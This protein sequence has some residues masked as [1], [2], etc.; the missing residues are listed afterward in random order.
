MQSLLKNIHIFSNLSN[1]DLEYLVNHAEELNLSA[2]MVL[3][4]EGTPSDRAY[5]I[6]KGQLELVKSFPNREVILGIHKS[7]EML[8]EK[9]LLDD[10]SH[11]VTIRARSDCE[12]VVITKELFNNLIN[13][14]PSAARAILH[15]INERWQAAESSLRKNEKVIMLGSL[16]A[17]LAHE[18]NNPA[19]SV[20][21]GVK[22][23]LELVI[24]FEKSLNDLNSVSLTENQKEIVKRLNDRIQSHIIHPLKLDTIK[25]NDRIDTFEIWLTNQ[26]IK[27]A[28]ELAP[29]LVN[30]SFDVNEVGQIS[31]QF[32][33][34]QRPSLFRWL[35]HKYSI[36]TLLAEINYGAEQ[37]LEIGKSLKS[38]SYRDQGSLQKVQNVDVHQGLEDSLIILRGLLKKGI[39]II[40]REFEPNLPQI[41]ALSSAKLSQVWINLLHNAID[42]L[43]GQEYK[44]IIIRTRSESNW[45][46]VDFEDN[47]SGIPQNI[48]EKIFNPFFTTKPEGKGTG[49]GLDISHRI[50]VYEHYGEISVSSQPGLTKFKVK[51]PIIF[52]F[53]NAQ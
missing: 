40:K 1:K 12:L 46:I 7:G 3:V 24:K 48:Q 39:I 8:E 5:I 2:K 13:T 19:T 52:E 36:S 23:L 41:Q 34:I 20:N 37:I 27:H 14:S 30:L 4:S 49:L 50:V 16:T 43:E 33:I 35:H 42:A 26:G 9:G 21:R 6:K 25:L 28:W 15:K 10:S 51:L 11:T 38:Y 31:N 53:S 45:V 32:D 29:T 17:E 22:Q 47:G 18:I 44:E